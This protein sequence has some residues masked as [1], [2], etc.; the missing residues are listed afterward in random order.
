VSAL[1]CIKR[2]LRSSTAVI[3]AHHSN[4]LF[5]LTSLVAQGKLVAANAGIVRVIA[6]NYENSGVVLADLIQEGNLG[7]L[8]AADRFNPEKGF[9]FCTYAA[10]W[11]RQRIGRSI[12]VHSRVIRLP[13]Y[14]HNL[15][16]TMAKTTRTM[17]MELGRKPTDEE[18]AARMKVPVSKVRNG[19]RR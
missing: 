13:V 9:K 19:D 16:G 14:V 6:R 3:L 15:L 12:A 4:P 1:F 11:V 17:T 2:V 5:R 7:L 8:E 18:V 10:W